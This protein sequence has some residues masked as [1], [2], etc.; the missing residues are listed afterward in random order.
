MLGRLIVGVLVAALLPAGAWGQHGGGGGFRGGFV[1]R[2]GI[3]A[4]GFHRGFGP[5]G[6]VVRGG[7]GFRRPGFSPGNFHRRV[8]RPRISYYSFGYYGYPIGYYEDAYAGG[9]YPPEDYS[10]MEYY[11]PTYQPSEQTLQQQN[12]QI[13]QDEISS[14]HEQVQQLQ[15]NL[16]S[17]REGAP[18]NSSNQASLQSEPTELVFRDGHNEEVDNYA[19]VGSTLWVFNEQQA[20]K[21]QIAELDIPATRKANDDKGVDFMLPSGAASKR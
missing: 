19:I 17:Q 2:G 3:S 12:D 20:R 1:S 13:Q 16:N 7:F 21:I 8:F 10:G 14:L 11:S 9:F 4:G 18:A 6:V 5:S 15:Q